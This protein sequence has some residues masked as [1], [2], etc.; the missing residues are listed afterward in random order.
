[1][2]RPYIKKIF[3]ELKKN[4]FINMDNLALS[5]KGV[6]NINFVEQIIKK[7]LSSEDTDIEWRCLL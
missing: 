1:M 6:I 5:W 7:V 2:L 3:D 4:D